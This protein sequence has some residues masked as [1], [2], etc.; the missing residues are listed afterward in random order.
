MSLDL[1]P[2]ELKER[3]Q[4]VVWKH[5]TTHDDKPTKI[6]YQ[7]NGC[8]AKA[9]DPKTWTTFE[10]A[11]AAHEGGGFSGVGYVFSADDPYTGV[12]LDD[13]ID[14]A[15]GVMHI[16]AKRLVDG[17]LAAGAYAETSPSGQGVKALVRATKP[18]EKCSTT[19]VDWGKKLELFDRERYFTVT[20]LSL[21]GSG[22]IGDG[23]A[24]IDELYAQTFGGDGA[25]PS[26]PKGVSEIAAPAADDS[27]VVEAAL[28]EPA[29]RA[30]HEGGH[31]A[32]DEDDLSKNDYAYVCSLCRVT[33]DE[34]QVTRIWQASPL[35]DRSKVTVRGDYVRGTVANAMAETEGDVRLIEGPSNPLA[36]A[37]RLLAERW[38]GGRELIN[39]G[40][41]FWVHRGTHWEEPERNE[42]RRA[43]YEFVSDKVYVNKGK[44]IP[45]PTTAV[46]IS[47]LID[48][49]GSKAYVLPDELE[50]RRRTGFVAFQNCILDLATRDTS[51][52]TPD[53]FNVYALPFDYDPDAREMPAFES[54][55]AS[56]W[57]D[58]PDSAACLQEVTGY[59]LAGETAM[60]KIFMLVGPPRSGKGTY[61]RLLAALVGGGNVCSPTMSGLATNFGLGSLVGTPVAV[62]ADARLGNRN[63][64]YAAVE[65]LLSIS[66]E[67]PQ[68]IPRKYKDDWN[69]ALPTRFVVLTNEVPRFRDASGALASRFITLQ[70][71][72]SFLNR[73]DLGL[74]AKL[75]AEAP[76]IVNW[77]LEGRDRLKE[78]GHFV[79]PESGAATIAQLERMAAPVSTF[80]RELYEPDPAG[81]EVKDELFEAWEDWCEEE[82]SQYAG[83]K[84]VFFR[85]LYAAFPRLREEKRRAGSKRVRVIV[86]LRRRDDE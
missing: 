81:D 22:P 67:D 84:D 37:Q 79:Q 65:R 55:L 5:E 45:W 31:D 3:P 18:G 26:N 23:Q 51:P 21:N 14:P 44:R 82:G 19:K 58:D 47:N 85:D 60:Q 12:D 80:V 62:I 33:R 52:H 76:A 41:A 2:Q 43:A 77:A 48:A 40:G 72:E 35:G 1:V 86:G 61:G 11:V 7:V 64:T 38:D 70:M 8:K 63:D 30:L 46:A 78:R 83:N 9:N 57:P 28:R 59:L 32:V 36:V 25:V 29:F 15:T 74:D 69:G 16:G 39:S 66:G 6:P 71:T 73:E 13:C 56:V 54:F 50:R 17:L 68:T 42:L 10:E 49:L 75:Q 4:W 34:D 53:L 20:G 27:A 24:A